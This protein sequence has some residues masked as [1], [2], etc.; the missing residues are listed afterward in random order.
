MRETQDKLVASFVD[1]G[2]ILLAYQIG[3]SQLGMWAGLCYGMFD[4]WIVI[5]QKDRI[6]GAIHRT[7]ITLRT[8][9]P[10]RRRDI[11]PWASD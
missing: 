4:A 6:A 1:I 5:W 2:S 8:L 10:F 7:G 9:G 3:M 11:L